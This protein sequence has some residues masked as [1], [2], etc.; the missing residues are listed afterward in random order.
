MNR[1]PEVVMVGFNHRAVPLAVLEEARRAVEDASTA[2]VLALGARGAVAVVTCHRVELYVEAVAD[3]L[4]PSLMERWSAGRFGGEAPV[5]L[6]GRDVARHLLRVAAGLE[7][8]VLGD[9]NVVG[10]IREAYRSACEAQGVGPLLHRLFHA[11]FRAGK[12]VR[13][14]TGFG[15][16]GRSLAGEAVVV[17]NR[18]L[19]GLAGRTVL[20]LGAGEMARTAAESL[21][22]RGV[23]R[24]VISNRSVQR[25]RD[26]AEATGGEVVP[27][28]WRAG[29]L[30]T[31]DAVIVG[32]GAPEPVLGADEL[33][34]AAEARGR[35]VAVDLSL[36]RNLEQPEEELPQLELIDLVKLT[37]LLEGER[38]RRRGAVTLAEKIVEEEMEKWLAWAGNRR[39]RGCPGSAA[40][41]VAA[42]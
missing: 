30:Q 37:S 7:A 34:A 40:G 17:I 21:S 28:S 6:R 38:E 23:E 35:L 22:K 2:P 27:W 20:V 41:G 29:V 5:V 31:V 4:I 42:G 9:E 16:G 26:L 18:D 13:T 3:D 39:K 14:E 33:K 11:A 15:R 10:Q 36:P 1:E 12:R 8:A 32:T 25:A 19:G 24:L